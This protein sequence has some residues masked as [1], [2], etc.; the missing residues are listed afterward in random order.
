[1]LVEVLICSVLTAM[2]LLGGLELTAISAR[3]AYV[4]NARMAAAAE[5]SSIIGEIGA[6]TLSGNVTDR[7]GWSVKISPLEGAQPIGAYDV[8]ISGQ[9]GGVSRDIS[10]RQWR[11][12]CGS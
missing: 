4:T 7:N 6:G 2:I 5:F 12:R 10:W 1:M 8:Y 3:M 11:I 9:I